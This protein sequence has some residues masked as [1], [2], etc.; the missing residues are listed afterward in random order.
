MSKID[1]RLAALGLTLPTAPKPVAAY[2]PSVLH[3]GLLYI[4]GQL[5]MVD[6]QLSCTGR[7]GQEVSLEAAQAAA[8][9][10]TLN[11]LSIARDALGDLD[12][13]ARIVK[14]GG[15][16]SSAAGFTDQPKVINGCSELL[17]E[18]FGE[19]GRHARAAV[20]VNALPLNAAVEIE[21]VMAVA[22]A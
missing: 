21:F 5:P 4:S 15:F 19:A 1:D 8:R 17:G 13:I 22:E 12:K 10:C 7:V 6:G 14:V 16:V 3:G 18:I 2:V 11:A 20:G 9:V